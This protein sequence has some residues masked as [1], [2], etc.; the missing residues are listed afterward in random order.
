MSNRHD[1]P[2]KSSARHVLR[3]GS[4]SDRTERE[5]QPVVRRERVVR[6]AALSVGALAERE[7]STQVELATL[8]LGAAALR[9]VRRTRTRVAPV[10]ELGDPG[11]GPRA[12]DRQLCKPRALERVPERAVRVSRALARD[13]VA[14]QVQ[15]IA[16]LDA[17]RALAQLPLPAQAHE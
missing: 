10:D 11:G 14:A 12:R 13:P 3:L 2:E 16:F 9:V 5:H 17:L 1:E 6:T 15:V 8:G 4:K 7:Q